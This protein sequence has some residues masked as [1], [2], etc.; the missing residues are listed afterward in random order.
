MGCF[1]LNIFTIYFWP[2]LLTAL[3]SAAL[4]LNNGVMDMQMTI[5]QLLQRAEGECVILISNGPFLRSYEN[6]NC[7]ELPG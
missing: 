4:H 7:A 2:P 5:V 1:F 3:L 6:A